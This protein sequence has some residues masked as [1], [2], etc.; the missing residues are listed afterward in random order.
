MEPLRSQ[1]ILD[2]IDAV[3]ATQD[4]AD[5][6]AAA[7]PFAPGSFASAPGGYQMSINQLQMV[8]TPISSFARVPLDLVLIHLPR[9]SILH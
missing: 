6:G 8:S 4:A 3:L 1:E 9:L 2:E 7:A 5:G